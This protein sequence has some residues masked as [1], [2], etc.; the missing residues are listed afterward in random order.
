MKKLRRMLSRFGI[1][2]ERNRIFIWRFLLRLPE[3]EVLKHV[4][5]ES[6]HI[7]EILS[8]MRLAISHDFLQNFVNT[9]ISKIV[10]IFHNLN[11]SIFFYWKLQ[12][13][14]PEKLWCLIKLTLCLFNS[15]NSM[16]II[17][18]GSL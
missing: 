18:K 6:K 10:R 5:P 4:K 3:N 13:S 7:K 8:E 11:Q 14:I 9:I 15:S 12:L 16:Q 1:Y 2:P 17:N